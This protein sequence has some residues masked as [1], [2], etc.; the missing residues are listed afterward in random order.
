MFINPMLLHKVDSPFDDAEWLSELKLDGIRLLYSTMNDS[1]FYTRHGNE[2]T[3]RSQAITTCSEATN[4][5][6]TKA[7]FL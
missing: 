7:K 2:V 6:W 4:A 5:I 3:E 1:N